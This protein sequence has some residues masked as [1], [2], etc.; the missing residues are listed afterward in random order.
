MNSYLTQ[1]EI[2]SLNASDL[3]QET[4]F[5]IQ[6]VSYSQFSI[7]RHYGACVFNGARYTYLAD[8]DELVRDDVLEFVEKR[9]KSRR[10]KARHV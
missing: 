4:P 3:S 5:T 6:G 7:S 2:E 8:C 9:R 10:K 1:T